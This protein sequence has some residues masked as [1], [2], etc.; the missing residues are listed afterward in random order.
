MNT[1]FEQVIFIDTSA[2]IALDDANEQFHLDA[3]TFREVTE[4]VVWASLNATSHE[5]YT[6]ARY[7]YGLKKALGLYDW[8]TSSE[9]MLIR[10]EVEDERRAHQHLMDFEDQDLSFHDALLAAVMMR[11]GA[12]RIF[13]FDH[14]FWS[15]G[16]EVVPGRTE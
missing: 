8:M 11:I 4:G 14:H 12:Y 13:A 5:T 1:A 2:V 3:K 16:F 7:R 15:F 6:L 9:F 10:F